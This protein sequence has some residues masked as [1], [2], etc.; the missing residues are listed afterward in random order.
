MG[1]QI[2]AWAE[3]RRNQHVP[4][5]QCFALVDQALRAAG[6]RSAA[7]YGRITGDA[8]YVWGSP[9][10]LEDLQPG[11]VIQFRNYRCTRV[12]AT[13][14]LEGTRPDGE[15]GTEERLHHTAI[16][17]QVSSDGGVWVLEQNSPVGA[18][19]SE[20]KLY[21]VSATLTSGRDITTIDFEAEQIWYYRP[22]PR[23]QS[24]PG[25]E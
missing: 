21:F 24:Q 25:A 7:D 10:D 9:T 18:P 8:D 11:D 1:A 17:Q 4:N 6:A 23:L 13:E 20:T 3:A 16:V 2:V 15:P 14:E 12:W 5:G 19:V 22:Q